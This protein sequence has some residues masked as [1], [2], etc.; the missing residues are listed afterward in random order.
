MSFP[1]ASSSSTSCTASRMTTRQRIET[2]LTPLVGAGR[3]RAQVVAQM[4]MSVTEEAREQYTPDS[5]VVRSEQTSEQTSR[6][7]ARPGG[8]PGALSNQPPAGGVAAAA[9]GRR[10]RAAT[11]PANA[12]A[13]RGAIL[14]NRPRRRRQAADAGEHLQESTRNYEI[15]RTLAYTRQPGGKLKRLTVAVLID[16]MHS[17]RQ[18]RQGAEPRPH[19]HEQIDHI[20]QLVKD[21]V[22]F[23]E[24]RGDARQRRE[25]LLYRG[26]ASRRQRTCRPRRSGKSR[27]SA[28]WSADRRGAVLIVLVLAVLRPLVRDLLTAAARAARA[29]GRRGRRRQ[30]LDPGRSA[31]PAHDPASSSARR[32]R[33]SARIPS[34]W[35]R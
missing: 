24:A 16:N 35:R 7:G 21:A 9:A 6:D 20:T 29:G 10:G 34:E 11:P 30:P 3:V 4:D 15:D 2:L 5:Q 27:S 31:T 32:G 18:G 12:R 13:G 28:T 19:A 22:G 25:R 1:C 8:V 26:D 14:P 33:W 23:D 17:H